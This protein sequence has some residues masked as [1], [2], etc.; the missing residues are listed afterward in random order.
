MSV[1]AVA[2]PGDG[3]RGGG[4]AIGRPPPETIEP[5]RNIAVFFTHWVERAPDRPAIV[6]PRPAP[7]GELGYDVATFAELDRDANRLGQALAGL[8]VRRGDRVLIMVPMSRPLYAL[9]VAIAKL[10]ATSVFCDPWVPLDQLGRVAELTSPRV[11]VGIGKAHWLRLLRGSFRRIP[12]KLVA[13][14]GS[15]LLGRRVEDLMAAGP[16]ALE[17]AAVSLDDTLLITFTSGST[18]RPKGANRTH[19]FVN[20]Q[21]AAL[22]RHLPR[23]PGDV[24]LPALPVFVLQNLSAGV[25]SVL[26]L[27]DFKRIAD[28][29]PATIVQQVRDWRVT[30]IG[31]SPAYLAPIARWCRERGE[32]LDTVRGVVAGGAPVP[33]ALLALLREVCPGARGNIQ[34]LYGS[35]EAEPVSQIE[36]DEVLGETAALTAAGRGNCVGRPGDD[37]ELRVVRAR[38]GPW[39]LEGG[40]EAVALPAGEVGE[41]LVTGA[42]VQK[43]YWNDPEAG[44]ANKVTGPDGRIWHRMGDLAWLDERGRVWLVGR[45][46]EAVETPRGPLYPIQVEEVARAAPGVR[47]AALLGRDRQALLAIVAEGDPA[48]AAE[49]ARA[50]CAARGLVVDEVRV[51]DA[52]P[53]DPRHNAKIDRAALR[54]AVEGGS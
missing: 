18:G 21:G 32:T 17:T 47:D 13:L 40:W 20:M 1:E 46:G 27:V 11:F 9:L 53:K 50:G 6:F 29:D 22:D 24:D 7:G 48:R 4:D 45:L 8:G 15:R 31:G 12:V 39:Q 25:T 3:A 43:D 51:L 5:L 54:A 10:G 52:I 19:G 30:T 34:V 23:L 49:A 33:A 35:T 16:D 37:V 36:A 26:P 38:A 2:R 44:R 42:H 14:G 28:V 41:V